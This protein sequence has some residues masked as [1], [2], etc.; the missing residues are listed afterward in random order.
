MEKISAIILFFCSS[1]YAMDNKYPLP[2]YQQ[3]Y[4]AIQRETAETL[5]DPVP[6]MQL[7]VPPL[8]NP[9]TGPIKKRLNDNS[10]NDELLL[11]IQMLED[12]L[13]RLKQQLNEQ[14]R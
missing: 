3:A 10:I 11:Q 9:A 7:D 4:D 14:S 2:N 8:L 1:V 13:R 5:M 6:Q 12:E